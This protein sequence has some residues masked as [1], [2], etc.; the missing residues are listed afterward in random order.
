MV[1]LG[2]GYMDH[3]HKSH[4]SFTSKVGIRI[5]EFKDEVWVPTD[6]INTLSF[7][8]LLH[9]RGQGFGPFYTVLSII[10]HGKGKKVL[11]KE[12]KLK[13]LTG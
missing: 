7:V 8:G 12:M 6:V 13:N 10:F 4:S 11:E 5:D 1:Y 2:L 3:Q 9:P